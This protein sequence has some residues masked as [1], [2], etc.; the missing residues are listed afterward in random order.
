MK[1]LTAGEN[2]GI[3][4]SETKLRGANYE[5]KQNMRAGCGRSRALCR[6]SYGGMH[7]GACARDRVSRGQRAHL[8][9]GR[10]GAIKANQNRDIRSRYLTILLHYVIL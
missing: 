5:K 1:Y 6:L 2:R 7:A 3:M 4:V 10:L 9:A 8:H